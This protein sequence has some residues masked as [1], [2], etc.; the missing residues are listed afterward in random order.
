MFELQ[1][2][3]IAGVLS[4]RI[5]LPS[6][7][8]MMEDIKSLYATLEAQGIQK[9][10]T[11]RMGIAQVSMSLS[12]LTYNTTQK[13]NRTYINDYFWFLFNSLSTMIGWLRN[14]DAQEQ[15]SGGKRCI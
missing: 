3:W 13:L 15:R 10:Y 9:R 4:G 6:K 11:H 12:L 2:K 14:V 1:S 5:M 8:D 7:E